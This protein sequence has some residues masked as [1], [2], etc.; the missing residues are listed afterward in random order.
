[1]SFVI[2]NFY[3]KSCSDGLCK[4]HEKETLQ[5]DVVTS[6][7]IRIICACPNHEESLN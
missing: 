3:C 4:E 5:V 2:D 6:L 1:M 7:E